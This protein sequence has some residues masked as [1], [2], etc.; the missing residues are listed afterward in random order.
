MAAGLLVSSDFAR[1]VEGSPSVVASGRG[2]LR[3]E[4]LGVSSLGM[5]GQR[6]AGRKMERQKVD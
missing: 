5:D 1:F 3:I 6:V 2:R 4:E